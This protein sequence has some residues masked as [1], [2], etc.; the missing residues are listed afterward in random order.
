[1]ALQVPS[2]KMTQNNLWTW[3]AAYLFN[4]SFL[5]AGIEGD[6]LMNYEG[7]FSYF[8]HAWKG[9]TLRQQASLELSNF[10]NSGQ[11][12]KHSKS[13]PP[14]FGPQFL[15][16]FKIRPCSG[17]LGVPSSQDFNIMRIRKWQTLQAVML[18]RSPFASASSRF[19]QLHLH[20]QPHPRPCLNLMP[21]KKF[22]E[23]FKNTFSLVSRK[24]LK[25]L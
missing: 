23:I 16:I 11:I 12:F 5:D 4:S 9:D 3:I 2:Q 6:S 20:P 19:S 8:S 14:K 15:E 7:F 1:M 13:I 24:K 25:M 21:E 22:S 10:P 17:E 18:M